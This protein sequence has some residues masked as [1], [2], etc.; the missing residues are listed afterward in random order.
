MKYYNVI[1]CFLSTILSNGLFN[2]E[3]SI[4]KIND[5]NC[6]KIGVYLRELEQGMTDNPNT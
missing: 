1:K 3:H 5:G 2:T 6:M 4:V